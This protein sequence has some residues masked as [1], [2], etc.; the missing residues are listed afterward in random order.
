MEGTDRVVRGG[1]E[2]VDEV[3]R[4]GGEERV[5]EEEGACDG[6]LGRRE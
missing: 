6:F 5:E 3:G 2:V 4:E 1:E